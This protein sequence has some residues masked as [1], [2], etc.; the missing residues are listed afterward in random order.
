ME[1]TNELNKF[2]SYIHMGMSV[3][4]IYHDEAEKIN[5]Q[6]L[7]N[8]IVDIEEIFKRHE[9][10]ITRL[11]NDLGEEATNSLTAAGVMGVYKEKLK[12]F[13]DSFDIC[14]SALKSTNMGLLSA[15]KFFNENQ[16]LPHTTLTKIVDVIKDYDKIQG[17][18]LKYLLRNIDSNL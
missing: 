15:I 16:D 3:Y 12:V 5:D 14:H 6:E 8:L 7:I 9:E 11:I 2:L 4:R 18:W 1:K 17:M 10:K 13:E